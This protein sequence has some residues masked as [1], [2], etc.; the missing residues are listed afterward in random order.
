MSDTAMTAGEKPGALRIALFLVAAATALRVAALFLSPLQLYP[1][2]AQYWLWS[3]HLDWG[4]ASKPP[5]IAW[6]IWLTTSIGGDAETWVRLS[7]PFLHAGAALALFAAGRRLYGAAVGLLACVLWTLMP[8]VQVSSLFIATD[9]PLM[10]CLCLALWAYAAMLTGGG[11]KAAAGLGGA[12]GLAFLAK[13]SALFFVGGLVLHALLDRDAR[14]SWGRWK[15]ALVLAVFAAF[16][17]PNIA[18]NASHHFAAAT[19]VT[20]VNVQVGPHVQRFDAGKVAE[21][22]LGQFGVLGPIPYGVLIAG[23]ILAIRRRGLDPRDRMLLCILAPPVLIVTAESVLSRA[24][25][26]WAAAGYTAG[27]VLAAAWLVRWRA[28]GWTIATIAIQGL[29]ALVFVA[30]MAWPQIG[31]EAGFARRFN[32]IR[33]W[34]QVAQGVGRVVEAEAG[35]TAVAVDDRYMFNEIAYY[36]RRW[37]AAPGAPPLRMRP[38]VGPAL[39]EAELSAP[40]KTSEGAHVLIAEDLSKPQKL[41]G[42]FDHVAPRGGIHVPLDGK[43]PR[44]VGLY[45]GAGFK[46]PKP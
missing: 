39:N 34:D 35:L 38:P 14:R 22:V 21:F 27:T 43:H 4:Y 1:D 28:R 41:T 25:A 40:L 45:L 29:A 24:H 32:R 11:R 26:H 8:A 31:D 42:D 3:R 18:W 17:A 16:A 37:L 20:Q 6:L 30:V 23:V 36:G 2:E 33:G 19:H 10:A 12:L 44:D 15:W 5:L 13:Y 7:A 46:G 9:A